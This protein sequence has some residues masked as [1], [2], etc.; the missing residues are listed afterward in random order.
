MHSYNYI[1]LINKQFICTKNFTMI[2][3]FAYFLTTRYTA[4]K[5]WMFPKLQS[6]YIHIVYICIQIYKNI[7]QNDLFAYKS[8]DR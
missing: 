7:R 4:I 5:L 2:L 3:V 1:I 6:L 8:P